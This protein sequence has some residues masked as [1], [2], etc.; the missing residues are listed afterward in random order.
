MADELYGSDYAALAVFHDQLQRVVGATERTMRQAGLRS[1]AFLALL[2]IKNQSAKR[3]VTIGT[4]A[5][6]L[7]IDRTGAGE[8]LEDLIRRGFVTRT[9]DHADRRRFLLTLSP[10]GE[11]WLRPLAGDAMRDLTAIGPEFL[12]NLR[13]VVAHAVS[14]ANR[15]LPEAR[16][17]I[18]AY[19]WRSNSPLPV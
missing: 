7:Q 2:A 11:A 16:D 1:P 12:R 3:A 6:S 14:R 18:D 10:A 9:R 5:Q 17:E 19:A 13:S 8:I 4:L 15:P